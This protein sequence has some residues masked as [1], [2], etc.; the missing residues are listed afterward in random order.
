MDKTITVYTSF[1]EM[2]AAEL[3]EWQVLPAHVRLRAVAEMTL[4]AYRMKESLQEVPRMDRTH[5]V[6]L[7]RPTKAKKGE[8]E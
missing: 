3:R 2:K 7:S 8:G 4:A 5:L 1:E 6:E